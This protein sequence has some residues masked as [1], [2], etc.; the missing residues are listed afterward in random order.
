MRTSSFFLFFLISIVFSI[1]GQDLSSQFEESVLAGMRQRQVPGMITAVYYQDSLVYSEVHGLKNIENQLL[2]DRNT[3]FNLGSATKPFI[4]I[5]MAMLVEQGKLDWD[6]KVKD[7][8][9]DFKLSDACITEDA[10]I[11]DLFLHNLGIA[12]N[13]LLWTLDSTSTEEMLSRYS[14][15]EKV[16]PIR[17][18]FEYNNMLYVIA[19]EVIEAVSGKHWSEFVAESIFKPL[20]MDHS[21]ARA[22]DVLPYGNYATPYLYQNDQWIPHP[23]NLADQMGASG[24]IWSCMEDMEHFLEFLVGEGTYRGKQLITSESF[25]Y[26]TQS[27]TIENAPEMDPLY[28]GLQSNFRNYGIGWFLHDY[29]G[30]KVVYH[31]GSIEGLNAQVGFAPSKKL[32]FFTLCNRDWAELWRSL[33]YKAIDLWAFQDNSRDHSQLAINPA[34]QFIQEWEDQK[35]KDRNP[36]NSPSLEKKELMGS[37]LHPMYGEA[38]VQEENERLFVRFNQYLS[39]ELEH[40][41]GDSYLGKTQEKFIGWEEYFEFKSGSLEVFGETFFKQEP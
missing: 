18:G 3:V 11:K 27:H 37:Y 29:R 36:A 13:D 10:R 15:S 23:L 5:A 14:H 32:A 8:Y 6:D 33:F 9:A 2:V 30:E 34:K 22:V 1:H 31:P 35:A 41:Y 20:E 28:A 7:H 25:H 38:V 16:H 17:A 21:F 24:N 19:G 40:W 4:G 12:S 39:F 26:L